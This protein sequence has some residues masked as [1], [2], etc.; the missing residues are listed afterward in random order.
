MKRC[1]LCGELK[2][3][4]KFYTHPTIKGAHRARCK[5]CHHVRPTMSVNELIDAVKVLC[6]KSGLCENDQYMAVENALSQIE[7]Y[8]DFTS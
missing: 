7:D 3:L 4:A 6:S 8:I 1:T 2:P 5:K